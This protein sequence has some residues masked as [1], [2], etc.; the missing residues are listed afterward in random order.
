MTIS[1]R[2]E[3]DDEARVCISY[4]HVLQDGLGFLVDG[5]QPFLTR[6]LSRRSHCL[7]RH[8]NAL[9]LMVNVDVLSLG[10]VLDL[11]SPGA[12]L[13]CAT[14]FLRSLSGASEGPERG[15]WRL[16]SRSRQAS[17]CGHAYQVL[18][19]ASCDLQT[20]THT[21]TILALSG[22]ASTICAL[23]FSTY[24]PFSL[25]CHLMKVDERARRIEWCSCRS[26]G[27]SAFGCW[28]LH[29]RLLVCGWLSS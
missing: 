27:P 8:R 18:S 16:A 3:L 17:A 11:G 19:L 5:Q 10:L 1:N 15:K 2:L 9:A 21:T 4:R 13:W 20:C 23:C 6:W 28:V 24:Q 7:W 25:Q 29:L 14:S 12:S 22:L 26:K